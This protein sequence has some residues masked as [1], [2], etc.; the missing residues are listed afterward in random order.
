MLWIDLEG[1]MLLLSNCAFS[2]NDPGLVVSPGVQGE[3]KVDVVSLLLGG[4]LFYAPQWGDTNV[5]SFKAT[6]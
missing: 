4:T 6:C 2:N 1:H 5:R 3:G